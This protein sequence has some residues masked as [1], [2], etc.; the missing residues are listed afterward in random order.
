[1]RTDTLSSSIVIDVIIFYFF[2]C[3]FLFRCGSKVTGGIERKRE[4]E[5]E[6]RET[7]PSLKIN[8]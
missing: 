6:K 8:I 3:F 7:I 1:M 4:G 2:R 5:R